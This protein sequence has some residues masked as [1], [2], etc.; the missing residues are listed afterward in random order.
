MLPEFSSDYETWQILGMILIMK[1]TR[2]Q[3]EKFLYRAIPLLTLAYFL[4]AYFYLKFFPT[5][6]T[7]EVV[8]SLGLSLIGL[9]LYY[10]FY[11]RYHRVL[12]H[13]NSFEVRIDPFQFQE[14]F[15]YR[16][17][18]NVEVKGKQSYQHVMIY[19]ENGQKVK[20]ANVDEAE[21]I[22]KFLLQRC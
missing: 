10:A 19:L 14:E 2:K 20:L 5:P 8:A 22:R 21:Q 12:F 9:F 13:P 18:V 6:F 7:R 15:S 4:Q 11:H 17:I 3:H 1:I 16:E